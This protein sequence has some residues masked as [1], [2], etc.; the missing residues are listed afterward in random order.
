MIL[1]PRSESNTEFH[2]TERKANMRTELFNIGENPEAVL[3]QMLAQFL[4]SP[5][6]H[7]LLEVYQATAQTEILPMLYD[8]WAT[9][10]ESEVGM[11]VLNVFIFRWN[12]DV[13][14]CATAQQTQLSGTDLFASDLEE[15]C[16]GA[17]TFL[18]TNEL[19]EEQLNLGTRIEGYFQQVKGPNR[20][21]I[22]I[23]RGWLE[24]MDYVR[25]NRKLVR[26][27]A[28]ECG[29]LLSIG[30]G[31][32]VLSGT[33]YGYHSQACQERYGDAEPSTPGPAAQEAV[34][35]PEEIPT[36]QPE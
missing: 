8:I 15:L 6:A 28:V 29:R 4:R 21:A 19:T 7:R 20:G 5:G 23:L 22:S 3:D 26:C 24:L 18:Q 31:G 11:Q 2:W 1:L 25:G 27:T 10:K 9:A 32:E 30:P 17:N 16:I 34:A 12:V 36:T 14:T 33:T 13:G 35:E